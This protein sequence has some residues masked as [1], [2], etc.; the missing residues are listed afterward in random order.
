MRVCVCGGLILNSHV[1]WQVMH[2]LVV[3]NGEREEEVERIKGELD[4]E[5]S[6]V[7]RL[8]AQLKDLGNASSHASGMLA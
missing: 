6:E 1:T 5:R 4:A 7:G 2:E 3:E 8:A